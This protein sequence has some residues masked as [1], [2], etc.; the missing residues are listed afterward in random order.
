MRPKASKT[1]HIIWVVM[2]VI[3]IAVSATG[4]ESVETANDYEIDAF[5]HAY[6]HRNTPERIV[7]LSPNLTEMIFALGIAEGRLV[8]ITRFCDFPAATSR[9]QRVGGIVDPSVEGIL[10]LHPDLVLATRGNPV[11]IL[12]RLRSVGVPVFAFE[13]Q[14]GLDQIPETMRV[15]SR[16]LDAEGANGAID[17]LTGRLAHLR[18]LSGGVPE[19]GRPS[20]YYYDPMSPDWTAGPHTHISEVIRVAG[21]KNAADDS[22]VAWPRYSV[23]ALLA[24]P[25]DWLLVA[26]PGADRGGEE[27]ILRTLRGRPGWR[28]LSAVRDGKICFVPADPLLRP[29]PRTIETIRVLGRCLHPDLPWGSG[30]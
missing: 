8:G 28:S 24:R 5:G 15:L 22:P 11:A 25:P 23:E 16:L 10:A 12:D 19:E 26:V 7:S 6:Q 29:G 3:V 13:S 30:P 4:V 1:T 14:T 20:V 21:G 9:I 2:S 18:G 17:S 27:K